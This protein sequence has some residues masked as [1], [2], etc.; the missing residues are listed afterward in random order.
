MAFTI[1]RPSKKVLEILE[2]ENFVEI[3]VLGHFGDTM[4]L[5]KKV[6]AFQEVLKK[7]QIEITKIEKKIN[8]VS[9][10]DIYPVR[11]MRT[12]RAQGV[13]CPY[14]MGDSCQK[15][16]LHYDANY[17]IV[18]ER[19]GNTPEGQRLLQEKKRWLEEEAGGAPREDSRVASLAKKV[20][21]GLFVAEASSVGGEEN[22]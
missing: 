3:G 2:D 8:E 14:Y 18:M 21:E 15:P 20:D 19:F 22:T 7:G 10:E 11:N 12:S 17:E 1:E 16:L 9:K 4:Y 13:R 5:N 6:P